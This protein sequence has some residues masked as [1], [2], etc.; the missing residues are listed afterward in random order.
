V[1]RGDVGGAVGVETA[2]IKTGEDI[3]QYVV[4][5]LYLPLYM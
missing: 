1:A 5:S 4:Y 2:I 3:L